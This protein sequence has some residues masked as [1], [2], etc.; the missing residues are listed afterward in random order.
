MTVSTHATHKFG[1]KTRTFDSLELS[2]SVIFPY[3]YVLVVQRER[4]TVE[5]RDSHE[6]AKHFA[7]LAARGQLESEQNRGTTSQD[8]N[9]NM[10][11]FAVWSMADTVL[12]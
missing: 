9:L 6:I 8:D 10:E 1:W 5:I 11:T 12:R 2:G 3:G 4:E 7:I